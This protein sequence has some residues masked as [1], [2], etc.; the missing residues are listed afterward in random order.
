VFPEASG[1]LQQI[2]HTVLFH[3]RPFFGEFSILW[4]GDLEIGEGWTYDFPLD[5][6]GL[7]IL[8]ID[9]EEVISNPAISA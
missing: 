8:V 1:G 2:D 7:S 9:A 3:I 5:S 4:E 6:S